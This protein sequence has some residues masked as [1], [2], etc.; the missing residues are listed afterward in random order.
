MTEKPRMIIVNGG[1][2]GNRRDELIRLPNSRQPARQIKLARHP[3][4]DYMI[5]K[6]GV[7]KTKSAPSASILSADQAKAFLNRDA[8]YRNPV[9]MK[10]GGSGI[11]FKAVDTLLDMPVAIK[12]LTQDCTETGPAGA[13]LIQEARAAM[14][15]SHKH[16]VRLH[17]IERKGQILYLVMEYI[18]GCTL[19]EIL[20]RDGHLSPEVVA[21][22]VDICEDAIGYAHRHGILHRD[23]KPDNLMLS[24]DGMLKIID[25]G[26]ASLAGGGRGPDL[27]GTPYFISPEEIR[28]LQIDQR[29]DIYSLGITIHELLTGSLPL[30]EGQ[31]APDPLDYHPQ[32]DRQ[33]PA[34][35]RHVLEKAFAFDPNARWNDMREFADAYRDATR[36]IS[37]TRECVGTQPRAA[38]VD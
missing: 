22:I 9:F 10:Q 11:L 12:I 1:T 14:Q 34:P 28:G 8:R 2:G 26:L 23:I 37:A 15:L 32:A 3:Q 24:Q 27:C 20:K 33:I 31:P 16:I 17:N 38:P 7:Q 29:S 30:P 5:I 18:D 4:S 6:P 19:R 25:L 13:M 36:Q 35:W 21:Q